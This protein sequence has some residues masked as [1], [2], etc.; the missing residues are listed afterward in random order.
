MY[1]CR[2]RLINAY[3]NNFWDGALKTVAAL[4]DAHGWIWHGNLFEKYILNYFKLII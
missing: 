2:E 4:W 1:H 3:E